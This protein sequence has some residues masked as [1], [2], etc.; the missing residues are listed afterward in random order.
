MRGKF[1]P[2]MKAN[3]INLALTG[4]NSKKI[5]NKL[6]IAPA[7]VHYYKKK[8]NIEINRNNFITK[9]EECL[10]DLSEDYTVTEISKKIDVPEYM[11]RH[12]MTL[13]NIK[14][15][16]KSPKL[17][18]PNN[19]IPVTE[20]SKKYIVTHTQADSAKH[21]NVMIITVYRYCKRHNIKSLKA[22]IYNRRK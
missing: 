11:I 6:N 10:N 15:K 2:I 17:R 4:M 22:D 21:F 12:Y 18:K 3:I 19:K 13:F 16:R 7:M 20:A 9:M 1:N 5:A 14:S 8:Y